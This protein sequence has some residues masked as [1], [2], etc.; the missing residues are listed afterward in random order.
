MDPRTLFTQDNISLSLSWLANVANCVLAAIAYKGL[1][2]LRIAKD[3]IKLRSR[4]EAATVAVAQCDR[5]ARDIMP[6]HME[7]LGEIHAIKLPEYPGPYKDFLISEFTQIPRGPQPYVEV[8]F[9]PEN[10]ALAMKVI[11][12]LNDV[13]AVA[14]YFEKG[15][16]DADIAYPSIA[17]AFCQIAERY[18]VVIAGFRPEKSGQILYTNIVGL[19]KRWSPR[20]QH[21]LLA[22]QQE[23]LRKRIS[24]LPIKPAVKPIGTENIE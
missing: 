19:Y 2:Q 10:M 7:L 4:R 24:S 9:K 13:E 15:I 20:L 22:D 18:Y 21:T 12:M 16:A 6:K 11:N 23:L 17:S 5:F 14:I 8:I 1:E 3:D